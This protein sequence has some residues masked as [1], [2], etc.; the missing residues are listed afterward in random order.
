LDVDPSDQSTETVA[1]EIDAATP[2]VPA[3]VF[4]QGE[5]SLVD[6]AA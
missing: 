1:N 4:P 6:S 3:K 2:D 5:R